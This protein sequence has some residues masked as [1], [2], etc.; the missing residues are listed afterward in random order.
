VSRAA[1][2]R[3][4]VEAQAAYEAVDKAD[5]PAVEAAMDAIQSAAAM[6]EA[7]GAA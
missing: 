6:Q 3:R 7:A 5:S 2:D 4:L 1:A